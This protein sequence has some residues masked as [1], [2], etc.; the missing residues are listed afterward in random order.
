MQRSVGLHLSR[1]TAACGPEQ[2]L[3]P[4]AETAATV[5]LTIAAGAYEHIHMHPDQD[6]LK[7]VQLPEAGPIL[8]VSAA[9]GRKTVPP[10]ADV[11]RSP[12]AG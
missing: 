12:G 1:E 8:Q 2:Y 6:H 10:A 3:H 5:N 9:T 4:P 11:T 7:G